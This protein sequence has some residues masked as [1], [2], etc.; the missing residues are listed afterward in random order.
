MEVTDDPGQDDRGRFLHVLVDDRLI[1]DP[2]Q[3][4][5]L[6]GRYMPVIKKYYA[7]QELNQEAE[8][9]IEKE[10]EKNLVDDVIK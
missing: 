4:K 8:D 2:E 6:G 10:A 1:T 5:R 3:A 7:V 9:S